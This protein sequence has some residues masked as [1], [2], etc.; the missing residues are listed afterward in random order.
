[1]NN[2]S[3]LSTD[4]NL[5]LEHSHLTQENLSYVPKIKI[6]FHDE[7]VCFRVDNWR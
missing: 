3:G 7:F 1:M 4:I 2:L 5:S 6:L